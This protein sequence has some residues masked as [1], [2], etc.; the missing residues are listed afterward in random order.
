MFHNEEKEK[1]N[2]IKEVVEEESVTF[3][4]EETNE[5]TKHYEINF[6]G[7]NNNEIIILMDN[8][9]ENDYFINQ[10]DNLSVVDKKEDVINSIFVEETDYIKLCKENDE[11]IDNERKK[12]FDVDRMR[13]VFRNVYDKYYEMNRNFENQRIIIQLLKKGIE[14]VIKKNKIQDDST[15]INQVNFAVFFIYLFIFFF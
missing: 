8:K 15:H 10:E 12:L 14:K 3:I 4:R 13:D 7:T 1:E 2:D 11:E 9:K 5:L 6:D